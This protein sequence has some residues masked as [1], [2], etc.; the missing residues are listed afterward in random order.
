MEYYHVYNRGVDKRTIFE[1]VQDYERF[2][3]SLVAF[4]NPEFKSKL[5]DVPYEFRRRYHTPERSVVAIDGYVDVHAYCLIPNHFHI[6]VSTADLSNLSK[7]MQRVGAAYTKYFN[8]KNDRSGVLFQGV[9]KKVLVESDSQLMRLLAYV[10]MN[11]KVHGIDKRAL[12]RSSLSEYFDPTSN[13][14]SKQD[15]VTSNFKNQKEF[16]VFCSNQV[17]DTL[18]K[19]GKNVDPGIL[20]E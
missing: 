20:L 19:R 6:L 8:E 18:W 1:D 13:V 3:D 11:N 7:Y 2:L 16:V 12:F 10:N 15:M 9:Y 5:R 17:S 14:L 4:N